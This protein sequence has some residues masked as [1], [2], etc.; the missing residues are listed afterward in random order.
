MKAITHRA[1]L[2]G[3]ICAAVLAGATAICSAQDSD[4]AAVKAAELKWGPLDQKQPKGIQVAV[5][6]GDPARKGT[7]VMRVKF[8]PGSEV[9]SHHHS[10]TEYA[11]ILSGRLLVGFGVKPDKAKAIELRGGDF[12]FLKGG[13]H[14]QVWAVDETVLDFSAEGPF[15]VHYD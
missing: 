5:L 6:A 14:H 11:S 8:P 7:F 10:T 13:Q 1:L 2:G 3:Y 15:D 4:F 9:A 12:F